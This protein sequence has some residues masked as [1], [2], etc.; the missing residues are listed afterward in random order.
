MKHYFPAAT[1]VRNLFRLNCQATC[2]QD[3]FTAKYI[4]SQSGEAY[5][6]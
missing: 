3:N 5:E 1:R 2:E 6:L 4:L